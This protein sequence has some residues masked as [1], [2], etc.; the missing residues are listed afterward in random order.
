LLALGLNGLLL[1]ALL[2]NERFGLV[3][4][5]LVGGELLRQQVVLGLINLGVAVAITSWLFVAKKST[6]VS[7]PMF[8][9]LSTLLMR[10]VLIGAKVGTN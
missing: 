10:M 8:S 7:K 2:L 9:S 4:G 1:F 6:A 5:R 3:F